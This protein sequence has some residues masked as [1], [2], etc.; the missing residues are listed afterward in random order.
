MDNPFSAPRG[1]RFGSMPVAMAL[2]AFMQTSVAAPT[3]GESTYIGPLT[4]VDACLHPENKSPHRANYYG[5][6]L[7]WSYEHEGSL[8]F[9]FGDTIAN[10]SFE[11]IGHGKEIPQD[12]AFGTIDLSV[13]A[14]PS[15]IT[16]NN[17]PYLKLAQKRNSPEL[18]AMDTGH[19][20]D[21]LKTPEGGFS[22]GS[23]EFA[24]FILSKPQGCMVDSDCGGGLICD[25]GLGYTGSKYF[26][27]IGLTQACI[28]GSPECNDDTMVGADG[29]PIQG[30]G[31]CA[32]ETSTFWAN[33]P[34]GRVSGTATRMRIGVRST[35]EPEKYELLQDWLTNK[36]INT[37]V[38]TVQNYDPDNG[39][40]KTN[41]DYRAAAAPGGNR[42]V[43][44]WGRPGFMGVGATGRSL[45][46]YFG[47]VDMPTGPDSS[48]NVRYFTGTD[49]QGIPRFSGSEREAVP[50]DLDSSRPGVQREER[51]DIVQHMSI[52]WVEHFKKWIMFYGGGMTTSNLNIQSLS[53]CGLLQF[54][55]GAEC[56]D[57][58]IGN[59]AVRMRTA[60]NP[61]GPWTPPQDVIVGGNPQHPGS[62]QYGPGGALYHP[63]C[64]SPECSP[65]SP[66][67]AFG[68]DEP[69]FFYGANIVEQWIRPAGEG[70][71]VLWNASTWNPYRV[72]LLRTRIDP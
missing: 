44:L 2:A 60:D 53:E 21:G 14:D 51:H 13:W 12:D 64:A 70:V 46:L 10:E 45:G 52:V 16:S 8:H 56:G 58:V 27:E 63:A 35:S 50:V 41:H 17:I 32:D 71:E 23:R 54:F 31:L 24:I 20:M 72:V 29:N 38:R 42:R 11:D 15:R 7:G 57:V 36:F 22:N 39:A 33:T 61:W 18:L 43:F 9:L 30:S 59:G 34:A 28:D 65:R 3:V 67:P 26:V 69:G 37:A 55:T 19:A 5:T 48:W 40:G 47:Y 62:G 4:G 49:A 6:D 25:N 66:F 68:A 1:T